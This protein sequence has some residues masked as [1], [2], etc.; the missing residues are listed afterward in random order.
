MKPWHVLLLLF[1]WCFW[2]PS[3]QAQCAA[4]CINLQVANGSGKGNFTAGTVVDVLANPDPLGQIFNGWTGD[5]AYLANPRERHTTLTVTNN[6]TKQL[7]LTANY[8]PFAQWQPTYEDLGPTGQ[9]PTGYYFPPGGHRG[10]IIIF[11]GAGGGV[12]TAIE[13]VENRIFIN[14]AINAG[15]AMIA[16]AGASGDEKWD[17]TNPPATN[18]DY[19]SM[20]S[21]LQTF[22]KRGYMSASDPLYAVG[23]SNGGAF[24]TYI[25]YLNNYRATAVY[26]SAGLNTVLES[27]T[28]PTMWLLAK[29]DDVVGP[30]GLNQARNNYDSLT[31]RGVPATLINRPSQPVFPLRFWRIPGFQAADSFQMYNALLKNGW[32]DSS[33][34]FI[35]APGFPSWQFS[36]SGRFAADLTPIGDQLAVCYAS[37]QFYSEGSSVVLDFFARFP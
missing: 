10:V 29:N 9:T 12:V 36:I 13:A 33:G 17:T 24:A 21:I 20:Q 5:I 3:A 23:I 34:F 26:I 16:S 2:L 19:Q 8:K 31:S 35:N 7:T 30:E 27:S 14:D 22:V 37:H 6:G 28:V 11:H 4:P 1:S 18:K 25:S 32:V 15:Y